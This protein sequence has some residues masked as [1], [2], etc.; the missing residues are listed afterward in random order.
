MG[1]PVVSVTKGF[2]W[3]K[4]MNPS[5]LSRSEFN[6]TVYKHFSQG[7]PILTNGVSLRKLLINGQIELEAT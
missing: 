7:Y 5:D 6:L 1:N 2:S 4:N 3:S